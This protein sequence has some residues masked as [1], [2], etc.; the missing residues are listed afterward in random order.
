MKNNITPALTIVGAG[1]C[2]DALQV[3]AI[4]QQTGAEHQQ[5]I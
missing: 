2:F 1:W 5:W 4:T 3:I